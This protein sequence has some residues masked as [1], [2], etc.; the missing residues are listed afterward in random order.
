MPGLHHTDLGL[1]PSLVFHSIQCL[2]AYYSTCHLALET[3][4]LINSSCLVLVL[5]AALP[6]AVLTSLLF[7][8]IAKL[9]S[10]VTWARALDGSDYMPGLV[11]SRG[12]A[13]WPSASAAMLLWLCALDQAQQHLQAI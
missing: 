9:D 2:P 3:A 10:D 8:Q 6:H 1:T 13:R 11:S 4:I 12:H 7:L 5:C